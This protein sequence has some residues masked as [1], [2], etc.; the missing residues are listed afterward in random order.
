MEQR[1]SVNTTSNMVNSEFKNETKNV[2][3]NFGKAKMFNVVECLFPISNDHDLERLEA[4]KR[5][6]EDVL[7]GIADR[8]IELYE[9]SH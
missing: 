3:Y 9:K 5:L 6:I 8:V 7:G 4:A 2:I 1:N